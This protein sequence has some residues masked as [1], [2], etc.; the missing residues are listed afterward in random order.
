MKEIVMAKNSAV[1]YIN[2]HIALL[3]KFVAV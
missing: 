2:R 1:E 3:R